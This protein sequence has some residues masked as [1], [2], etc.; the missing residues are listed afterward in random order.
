MVSGIDQA[1]SDIYRSSVHNTDMD[2]HDV[3]LLTE[4]RQTLLYWR[5]EA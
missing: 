5:M 3:T 2:R 4:A 1:L